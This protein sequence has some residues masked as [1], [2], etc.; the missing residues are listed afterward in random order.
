MAFLITVL[1]L[2][3]Y[4]LMMTIVVRVIMSWFSLREGNILFNMTYQITEPILAPLRRIIPRLGIF[5]LTPMVAILVLQ[6]IAYLLALIG[7]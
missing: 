2:L 7:Y 5:D 3:C 4:V 1:V 6:G